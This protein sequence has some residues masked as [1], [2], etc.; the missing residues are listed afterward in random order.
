MKL[1]FSMLTL[2]L[3]YY[4]H[5]VVKNVLISF[6]MTHILLKSH[7]LPVTFGTPRS[8]V[9]ISPMCVESNKTAAPVFLP[10]P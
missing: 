3:G 1:I 4:I 5:T 8:L 6:A 9:A 10:A 7:W 2:F